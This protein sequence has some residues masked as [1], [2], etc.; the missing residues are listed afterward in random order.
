MEL[1]MSTWQG[2]AFSKF[3]EA[4]LRRF[5]DPAVVPTTAMMSQ[6]W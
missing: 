5:M 2:L 4:T 3:D 1:R 6:V